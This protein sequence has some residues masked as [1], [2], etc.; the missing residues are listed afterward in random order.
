MWLS[1]SSLSGLSAGVDARIQNYRE[2]LVTG[3]GWPFSI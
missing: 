1:G 2:A 3:D